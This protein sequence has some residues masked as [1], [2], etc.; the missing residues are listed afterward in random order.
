MAGAA[1][2]V[3]LAVM[4]AVTLAQV[5]RMA[6]AGLRPRSALCEQPGGV[7]ATV[8]LVQ[9]KVTRQGAEVLALTSRA[10]MVKVWLLRQ[11]LGSIVP[12][13]QS[14]TGAASQLSKAVKNTVAS[15]QVG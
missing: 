1:V 15:A 5:G 10:V 7:G 2:Q 4:L 14:M 8:S 3:S 13:E 11:P 12:A 9:V 6:A